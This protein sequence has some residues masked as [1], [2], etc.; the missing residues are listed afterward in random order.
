MEPLEAG[1]GRSVL[2]LWDVGQAA[3]VV[4]ECRELRWHHTGRRED[5]PVQFG[6]EV[7]ADPAARPV[8]TLTGT[9]NAARARH[10]Q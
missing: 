8:G 7:A 2:L 10:V 5:D 3:D 1:D 6:V 4:A 9:G